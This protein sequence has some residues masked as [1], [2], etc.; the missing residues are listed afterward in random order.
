MLSCQEIFDRKSDKER[1]KQAKNAI[2]CFYLT[3]AVKSDILD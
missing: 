1:S 3:L 2:A